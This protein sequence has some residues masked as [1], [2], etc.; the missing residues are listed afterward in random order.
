[1]IPATLAVQRPADA[2]LLV[3]DTSGHVTHQNRADFPTLLDTGDLVIANDAATMPASLFGVHVGT[4]R[5]VEIR[6][7]GRRSLLPR[8]IARFTAVAFGAGDFHTPTEQRPLPPAF[9]PG[10]SL[11]LGP[12]HAVVIAVLGHPRLIEIEFQQSAEETWEG[13]ARHGRPIQYAYMQE[14][15]AIWDTWTR[16]ASLPV[17]FEA[18]SAGFILDWRIIDAIRVRGALFSTI[19]HAAGISSTGDADLDALLPLDEPYHISATTASLIN[20]TRERGGRVVAVGTTVVRALEDAASRDGHVRSGM[21]IATLRIGPLTQLR[22]VDT[23]ITGQHEPGTSHFE[24]LRAFQRDD[25]LQRATAEANARHYRAHEFGDSMFI[26]NAARSASA[27]RSATAAR[28]EDLMEPWAE[29]AEPSSEGARF[30]SLGPSVGT[31]GS[32]SPSMRSAGHS[33]TSP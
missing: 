11:R 24:L 18:P 14:P 25:V 21:G 27:A 2:R 9:K 6:L 15:L 23:L 16:I 17:A 13:L 19:T 4:G 26:A 12:L 33:P 32:P 8:D 22:I 5:P 30:S 28:S 20:A 1:M 29:A 7:A 10:E 31:H 3:V